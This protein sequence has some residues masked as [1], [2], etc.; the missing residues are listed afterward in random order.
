MNC[1]E[2]P[3]NQNCLWGRIEQ[4]LLNKPPH[5]A[6]IQVLTCT[7]QCQC[8]MS[9]YAYSYLIFHCCFLF[10]SFDYHVL[11]SNFSDCSNKVSNGRF[12]Y[13]GASQLSLISHCIPKEQ[14]RDRTETKHPTAYH[15]PILT[16][17]SR[18]Y[19]KCP[20]KGINGAGCRTC[21]NWR[22][23]SRHNMAARLINNINNSQVSITSLGE[24]G[25]VLRINIGEYLGD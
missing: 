21:G 22:A 3:T 2:S 7:Y 1:Y 18:I 23:L 24:D 19:I 12:I 17:N 8:S 13:C 16:I 11:K 5:K 25:R 9:T 15:P 4:Y 10:V 14:N 20:K 6:W